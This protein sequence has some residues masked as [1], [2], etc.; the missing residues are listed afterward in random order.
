MSRKDT[1]EKLLRSGILGDARIT[2]D[3]RSNSLAV[4]A[5]PASMKFLEELI[6]VLDQP[7]PTVADIKMF[8]LKNAD[9]SAAV[10]LLETLFADE[11]EEQIGVQLAGAEDANS[12][13]VPLR[14]SVDGRTNTVIAKGGADA[15][16]ES[17]KPFLLRLDESDQRR[18]RVSVLKL[19]HTPA[20]DIANSI[21]E[22]LEAKRALAEIDPTRTSASELLNQE[23]I[24]TPE[25]ISN[26]LVIEATPEY[27][28]EI[29]RIAKEL[30][31]QP[32]QVIIQA[33]LS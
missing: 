17:W 1:T 13:L 15:L 27:F 8:P 26:N 6:S 10:E 29:F 23:V 11:Q 3:T 21:N 18:R 12:G 33:L 32:S 14:F 28:D 22:F 16:R 20:T 2:A 7:T 31:K 24:V 4:S 30:D 9:A 5:P 25:P 19:R